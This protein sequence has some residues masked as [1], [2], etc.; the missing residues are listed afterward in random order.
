MDVE[1]RHV[2]KVFYRVPV[3]SL[4]FML[5]ILVTSETSVF[6]HKAYLFAWLDGDTVY[7]ESYFGGKKKVR[8]GLVRVFGPSGKELLHGKTDEKGEF[9]FKIPQKTDL[10]IVLDATM[11]HKTEYILRTDDRTEIAGPSEPADEKKELHESL[12]SPDKVDIEQIRVVV[13]KTVD[14]RLRPI[15]RALAKIQEQKGPGFIE[16]IGGI[17]Y[18]FGCMGLIL[19]FRDRKKLGGK[20]EK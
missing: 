12:T 18:I 10:R 13:E 9:S 16:V 20:N 1:W 5:T 15:R 17:G 7:T 6:A 2:L 19:Y 11:G 4:V 8:G 3:L 14:D